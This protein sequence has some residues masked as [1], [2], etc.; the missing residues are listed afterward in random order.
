M[1]AQDV[2]V[3]RRLYFLNENLLASYCLTLSYSFNLDNYFVGVSILV[4][5]GK[6]VQNLF[7]TNFV[8]RFWFSNISILD[9]L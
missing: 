3:S 7:A 1:T 9:S 5:N 6:K 4:R 8:A 2:A